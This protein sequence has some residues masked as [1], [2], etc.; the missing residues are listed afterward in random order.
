[1]RW[2]LAGAYM[3]AKLANGVIFPMKAKAVPLLVEKL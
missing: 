1:V 2:L 3:K